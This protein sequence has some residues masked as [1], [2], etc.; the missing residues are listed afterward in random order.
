ML[1]VRDRKQVVEFQEPARGVFLAKRIQHKRT[2]SDGP[3]DPNVVFETVIHDV[4]VNGFI[5]EKE[6]SF[7]FPRGIGVGDVTKDVFHVW[8]DGKPE[9]TFTTKQYNDWRLEEMQRARAEQ[10]IK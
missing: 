6:L 1:E 4:L 2:R 5:T 7:R 8:G 10:V 9:M 3:N